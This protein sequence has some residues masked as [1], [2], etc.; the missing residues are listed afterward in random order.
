MKSAEKLVLYIRNFENLFGIDLRG[1]LVI[2]V[3]SIHFDHWLLSMSR[4]VNEVY[5]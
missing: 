5:G 3:M 2:F 1:Q 4:W